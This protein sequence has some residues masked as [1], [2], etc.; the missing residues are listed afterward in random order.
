M[1]H[2]IQFLKVC[3]NARLTTKELISIQRG[4]FFFGGGTPCRTLK[5][6]SFNDVIRV[7]TKIWTFSNPRRVAYV[8]GKKESRSRWQTS[9]RPGGVLDIWRFTEHQILQVIHRD[10]ARILQ[11]PFQKVQLYLQLDLPQENVWIGKC[12]L[13]LNFAVSDAKGG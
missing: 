12:F 11:Y 6:L 9:K 13:E 2:S 5:L 7:Y 1:Y 8:W 4:Y 3:N 10:P